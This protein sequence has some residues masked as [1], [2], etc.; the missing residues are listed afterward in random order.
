MKSEEFFLTLRSQ[1]YKLKTHKPK[2]K[3]IY[4]KPSA[5]VVNVKLLGS[6]LDDPNPQPGGW[7]KQT[8][9]GD[10]KENNLVEEEEILPTQPNLWGDEED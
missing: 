9:D 10:A 8:L 5:E 1:T 6:V 3:K 7:S 4:K 2:M